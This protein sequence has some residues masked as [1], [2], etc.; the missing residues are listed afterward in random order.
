MLLPVVRVVRVFVLVFQ[1]CVKVL[2]LMPLGQVQP[3]AERHQ[4]AGDR[5]LHRHRLT[6]NHDRQ[7]RAEKWRDAEVGRSACGT[8]VTQ[9][10]DEQHK[11]H[12]ISGQA[13]GE[14]A[15][16]RGPRRPRGAEQQS[17]HEVRR[18]GDKAP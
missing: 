3:H 14:R 9:A 11:A 2:M 6:E 10:D 8:E 7:Q 12:A 4:R 5:Q 1:R 16:D 17:E 13:H 18:P 15:A